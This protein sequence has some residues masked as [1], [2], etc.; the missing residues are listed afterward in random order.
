VY[1]CHALLMES[2]NGEKEGEEN[3]RK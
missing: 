3:K 2:V 1:I